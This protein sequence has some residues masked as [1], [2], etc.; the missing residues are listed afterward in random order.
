M[1]TITGKHFMDSLWLA[2]KARDAEWDPEHKISLSFRGMELAGEVGELCNQL[3]KLE[4]ERMG[5]VGSKPDFEKIFEEMAD[6]MICVS[7]I[8]MHLDIMPLEFLN[9]VVG[10]FNKTSIERGLPVF[11]AL[12]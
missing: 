10:K 7:L 12:E 8:A 3:K 11:I 4:R 9:A 5:L 2:N 6:V 1:G